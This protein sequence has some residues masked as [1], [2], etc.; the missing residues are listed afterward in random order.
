MHLGKHI[1]R[2]MNTATT[3][4]MTSRFAYQASGEA[5]CK[6]KLPIAEATSRQ[7]RSMDAKPCST[8][9]C[10]QLR[11]CCQSLNRHTDLSNERAKGVAH[12]DQVGG[13]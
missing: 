9:E 5:S 2:T 7:Q 6:A 8:A 13:A 3:L 11:T 12:D 4:M 10:A 1:G